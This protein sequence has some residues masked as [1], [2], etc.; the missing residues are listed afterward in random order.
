VDYAYDP[1]G[2]L[3]LVSDRSVSAWTNRQL[4]YDALGRLASDQLRQVVDTGVPPTVLIGTDYTHDLDDKVR[5][6]KSTEPRSVAE[7]SYEY[8]GVGRLKSWTDSTGA[9]TDYRW[10]DSGNRVGVGATTY[11]YDER[12]R[13]TSG[14]GATYT[15]T[16]RGTVKSVVENGQTKNSA[17]DAFDRL[18]T[19]G[20]VQYSYDG[21]DRVITRN[22]KAF[23]Y[24]G[25]SNEAVSDGTRLISR[26]P[27]GKPISDKAVGSTAKGKMLFTDQRGDVV[28]RYLGAAVDGLKT[29]DP[30]GKVTGSSGDVSPLGY[31]GDWTDGDTGAV[32]MTARWYSPA[33]AQFASRDDWTL[34]PVPSV[35]ANRYTYGNADPVNGTDPSGHCFWDACVFEGWAIGTAVVGLAALTAGLFIVEDATTR[36]WN[37]DTTTDT[38]A[39]PDVVRLP[40]PCNGRCKEE[41]PDPWKP[42]VDGPKPPTGGCTVCRPPA[43]PKPPAPPPPPPWLTN[44]LKA[45]PKLVQGTITTLERISE[46]KKLLRDSQL[47]AQGIRILD[48]LT[49][50]TKKDNFKHEVNSPRVANAQ[51]RDEDEKRCKNGEMGNTIWYGPLQPAAGGEMRATGAA[52]C[53]TEYRGSMRGKMPYVPGFCQGKA[54]AN[55]RAHLVGN[56]LGGADIRENLVPFDQDKGNNSMMYHDVEKKIGIALADETI[57]YTATPVYNGNSLVPDAV[58]IYARGDKGYFCKVTIPNVLQVPANWQGCP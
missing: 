1:A 52:A 31:Q 23:Q 40:N 5:T 41:R 10:D 16:A 34:N 55:A 33:S 50:V 21:L 20:A 19:S 3:A 29:F 37:F 17:F 44:A 57:Y 58:K 6:K 7:N 32:N 51:D 46:V 25:L 13:L 54:L 39:R 15:Y 43:P 9:R 24:A 35:A 48:E 36:D 38:V 26:S 12:N 14:G 2:R 56:C 47:I 42:R 27:S 30:F 49:I 8:D 28:G 53:L 11:T 45:L 22:G 18:V 4:S